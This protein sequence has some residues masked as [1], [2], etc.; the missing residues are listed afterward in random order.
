[1]ESQPCFDGIWRD[2]GD[3]E[4]PTLPVNYCRYARE[5]AAWVNGLLEG[6]EPSVV[7]FNQAKLLLQD[8]W[9]DWRSR[10]PQKHSNYFS[11]RGH[12]CLFQVYLEAYYRLR[13]LEL[14][15]TP[16]MLFIPPPPPP[17]QLPEVL[18]LGEEEE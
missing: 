6:L 9:H 7:S 15:L 17:P 13:N 12:T 5:F 3:F 2:G 10:A 11:D 8:K 14:S 4:V 16:P 18:F 1:M